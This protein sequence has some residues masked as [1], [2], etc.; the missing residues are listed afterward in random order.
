VGTP[1]APIKFTNIIQGWKDLPRK[2]YLKVLASSS[3]TKEALF[4]TLPLW[5]QCYKSLF[6]INDE[7]A[8]IRSSICTLQ[9]CLLKYLCA[10]LGACPIWEVLKDAIIRYAPALLPII[11]L[12]WKDL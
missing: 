1:D 11:T 5:C 9:V 12:G 6:F 4:I 3:V 8:T 7:E 2:K 10:R